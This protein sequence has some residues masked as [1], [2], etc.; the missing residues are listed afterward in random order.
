MKNISISLILCIILF[1][2][3]KKNADIEPDPVFKFTIKVKP[4]NGSAYL[5]Y[6]E[7][8]AYFYKETEHQFVLTENQMKEVLT[9]NAIQ[10]EVYRDGNL[11]RKY[12]YPE[13][14]DKKI[15]MINIYSGN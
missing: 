12:V 13:V 9:I 1:A 10:A 3:C 8:S 2:S 5:A 11:I 15:P 14:C 4:I 7:F 6:N